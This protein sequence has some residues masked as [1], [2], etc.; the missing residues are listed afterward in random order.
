MD[1][2][3]MEVEQFAQAGIQLKANDFVARPYEQQWGEMFV[4]NLSVIDAL[5]NI[6]PIETRKL[7]S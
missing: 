3:Y 5:F 6:G 2:G 1:A 4:P 7:I